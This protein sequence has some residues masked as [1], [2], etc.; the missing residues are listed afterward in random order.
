MALYTVLS[1]YDAARGDFP[2]FIIDADKFWFNGENYVFSTDDEQVAHVA[3]GA[4]LAV[5]ADDALVEEDDTDE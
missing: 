3:A 4:V 1:H 2:S 5:V